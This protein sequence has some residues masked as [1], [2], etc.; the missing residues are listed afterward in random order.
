MD[1]T[2]EQD[3]RHDKVL[4][5]K[6]RGLGI[7]LEIDYDDVNHYEIDEFADVILKTLNKIPEE[8]WELARFK[9]KEIQKREEVW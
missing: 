3:F 1:K 7:Y 9:A 4:S 2:F 6:C 5:F 8:Q